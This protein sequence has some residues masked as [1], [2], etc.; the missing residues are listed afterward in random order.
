MCHDEIYIV[1]K[2]SEIICLDQV[3]GS[4]IELI[5]SDKRK[6]VN[7]PASTLPNDDCLGSMKATS[8]QLMFGTLDSI[9]DICHV[10]L[11]D[12]S[13]VFAE[14]SHFKSM[15]V[16]KKDKVSISMLYENISTNS[17]YN[18]YEDPRLAQNLE[19][20]IRKKAHNR[21]AIDDEC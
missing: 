19:K 11:T 5:S 15:S 3:C 18:S 8:A 4:P 17:V 20:K 2:S 10:S 9:S 6:E 1:N 13:S 7:V 16:D 12:S 14:T 21:K